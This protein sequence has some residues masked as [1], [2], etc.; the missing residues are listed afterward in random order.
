MLTVNYITR[1]WFLDVAVEFIKELKH[2]VNLNVILIIAPQTANYLGINEKDAEKYLNQTL[3]LEDVLT[4]ENRKRF[5]PYFDGANVLC[6]FEQHKETN[7]QNALGWYKL[8]REN[9]N[10]AFADKK[11]LSQVRVYLVAAASKQPGLYLNSLKHLG[12]INE[13]RKSN[14]IEIAV[15]QKALFSLLEKDISLPKA[16]LESSNTDLG[17]NYLQNLK[18]KQ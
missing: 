12:K 4:S 6:K 3:K 10:L 9:K 5:Y 2:Q 1:P 8:L 16:N 15:V 18:S 14:L 17:K 7:Y 13:G 11:T